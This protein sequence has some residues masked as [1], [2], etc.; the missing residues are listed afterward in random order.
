MFSHP[1]IKSLV[2]LRG[3]PR[4]CVYTE[5]IFGIPSVLFA[6]YASVYML[7]LGLVDQQIGLLSSVGLIIQ[8]FTSLVGGAITD[9]FGRRLTLLVAD[10]VAWSV[11]CLIWAVAQDFRYFMLAVLF[12]SVW[13][14]SHTAWTCLMVEDAE[15]GEVI[16][17]WTW[18]FIIFQGLGLLAPIAGFLVERFTLVPAM[19]GLY[20][21]SFVMMT[22]K[23]IVLFFN[24]TETRRG[25]IR[26]QETRHQSIFSMLGEYRGVFRQLLRSR[27]TLVVVGMMILLS[28]FQVVNS[29]FWAVLVTEK[30]HIPSED[31]A[32]YPFIRSIVMLFSF[33]V[34]TPRLTTLHFKRPMAWGFTGMMVAQ[35]ML[36][37][38]PEKNYLLLGVTTV[39]DALAF[40]MVG[41]MVESLLVATVDAAE[42]A[43]ISALIYMTILIFTS[44]FGWIAGQLSAMDRV[45]PFVLNAGLFLI[46]ALLVWLAGRLP[47]PSEPE[48]A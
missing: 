48:Q 30:L 3:N 33:F 14:I 39:V 45:Y 5:P 20:L 22:I 1:L 15:P 6:P 12:N 27:L 17:I 47:F 25:V 4:A 28:I 40:A 26:R 9:K 24:S 34:I 16:H 41:P 13:R 36:V 35:L 2:N 23:L 7:A 31:I 19:R 8:I 42:R 18:I 44:P 38:M 32:I 43:R 29:A 21:F 37:F 11:P 10:F 46:G